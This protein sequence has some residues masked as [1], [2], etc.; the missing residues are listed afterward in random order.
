MRYSRQHLSVDSGIKMA[1]TKKRT[2][3]LLFLTLTGLAIIATIM[4]AQSIRDVVWT[5]ESRVYMRS[6]HFHECI[7]RAISRTDGILTEGDQ[8][9][10]DTLTFRVKTDSL[11][12]VGGQIDRINPEEIRITLI[13]QE[14][15]SPSGERASNILLSKLADSVRHECGS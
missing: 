8:S 7:L 6:V 4:F 5:K 11:P 9:F 15:F 10:G 12:S 13:S 3:I 2:F 1:A 14:K